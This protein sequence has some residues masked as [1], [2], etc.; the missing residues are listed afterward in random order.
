MSMDNFESTSVSSLRL[1]KLGVDEERMKVEENEG[2]EDMRLV[3]GQVKSQ[4]S[5]LEEKDLE[6]AF[7][8]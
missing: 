2:T 6:S 4:E 7:G 8:C 1:S 3:P 5:I